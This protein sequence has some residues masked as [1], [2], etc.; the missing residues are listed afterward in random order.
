MA[1]LTQITAISLCW[2]L[3]IP[4][5]ALA[6]IYYVD[7]AACGANNGTS[8]TDAFTTIQAGA[9]AANAAGGGEVW[10]KSGIYT[11]F[12]S[13]PTSDSFEALDHNAGHPSTPLRMLICA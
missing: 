2:F 12:V 7:V 3:L 13:A 10:V 4:K 9:D 1:R 6:A 5:S 11:G 8:W